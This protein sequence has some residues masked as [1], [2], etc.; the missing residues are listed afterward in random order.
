MPA[1]IGS[2]LDNRQTNRGA[3]KSIRE[4]ELF[5]RIGIRF[6]ASNRQRQTQFSSTEDCFARRRRLVNLIWQRY[7]LLYRLL[8][9]QMHLCCPE[10]STVNTLRSCQLRLNR[11]DASTT[12]LC[13]AVSSL[14]IVSCKEMSGKGH[15][16]ITNSICRGLVAASHPCSPPIPGTCKRPHPT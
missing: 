15:R 9:R 6:P 1:T 11:R 16:N 12:D 3:Q 13:T 8:R 5:A 7:L 4:R 10:L 2:D 14:Q